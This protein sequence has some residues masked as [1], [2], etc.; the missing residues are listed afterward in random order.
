M[1]MA[2]TNG[3]DQSREYVYL[4]LVDALKSVGVRVN[5]FAVVSEIGA[6]R[7]SRGSDYVL[8]LKIM[9]QSYL[10]PGISVNFFSERPS[11]LPSGMSNG[12]IIGLQRVVMK[13]HNGDHYCVYNKRFSSFALFEGKMTEDCSPYQ[14]SPK[15]QRRDHDDEHLSQLRTL[16]VDHPPGAVLKEGELQLRRIKK[17][18]LFDLVLHICNTSNGEW[19]LFVWDGTDAPP[20]ML[21]NDLNTEMTAPTPLRPEELLLS[22][23]VLCSF[24]PVG[25]VLRVFA[26]NKIRLLSDDESTVLD[27]LKKY[28]A[29]VKS[30]AERLPLTCFPWPSHILSVD[31][32][33]GIPATLMD[34]LTC[35]QVKHLVVCVVRVVSSCPWRAEDL[36]SPVGGHFRIRVILEDP[37]ARIYAY[38]IKEQGVRC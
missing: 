30:Q 25:T 8:T 2:S 19:I 21:Q 14:I 35:K 23:E 31:G 29:R 15:F 32:Y 9:D 16:L 34:S 10:A 12:D 4:P 24:P 18:T 11:K 20:L 1:E 37:T 17:H 33:C 5:L 36:R 13:I 3:R 6:V 22:R 26:D 38:I 27:C 7:R 28:N